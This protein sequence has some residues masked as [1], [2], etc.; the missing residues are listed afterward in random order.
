M[1]RPGK[2]RKKGVIAGTGIFIFNDGTKRASAGL[3]FRNTGQENRS[4]RF[5]PGSSQ[6]SA[7]ATATQ[8]PVQSLHIDGFA[9]RKTVHDHADGFSVGLSKDGYF[10]IFSELR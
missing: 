5:L 7:G 4:I 1:G 3:I 2:I 10:D 8:K 6:Q 9:R